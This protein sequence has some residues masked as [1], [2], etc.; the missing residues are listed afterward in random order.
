MTAT[1]ARRVLVPNA[2]IQ[3]VIEAARDAGIAIAGLDVGRDY[4]R[5]IPPQER[6]ESV[7]DYIGTSGGRKAPR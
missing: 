1:R 5:T 3:R 4:V 6:G 2:E 7:A